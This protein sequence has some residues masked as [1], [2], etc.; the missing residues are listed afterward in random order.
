MAAKALEDS[1]WLMCQS[2]FASLKLSKFAEGL[3]GAMQDQR[4]NVSILAATLPTTPQ[5][6]LQEAAQKQAPKG[7][8]AMRQKPDG[9]W[10]YKDAQGKII[11]Q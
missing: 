7:A 3:C 9:T 2:E 11:G 6:T 8:V 4:E 10:E 5:K 1:L